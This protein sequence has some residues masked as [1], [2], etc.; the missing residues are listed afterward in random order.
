MLETGVCPYRRKKKYWGKRFLSFTPPVWGLR[1]LV[2]IRHVWL[3]QSSTIVPFVWDTSN[4]TKA[5]ILSSSD[6]LQRWQLHC[7]NR[8]K[9]H[10]KEK[11][12][13]RKNIRQKTSHLTGQRTVWSY[14]TTNNVKLITHFPHPGSTDITGSWRLYKHNVQLLS[15]NV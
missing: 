13:K 4:P 12:Q 2:A 14:L 8:D 15:S 5:F 3:L 7:L 6:G 10:Q 9:R 1:W 11:T